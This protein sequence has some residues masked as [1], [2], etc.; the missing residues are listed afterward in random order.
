[1]WQPKLSKNAIRNKK[2]PGLIA[3]DVLVLGGSRFCENAAVVFHVFHEIFVAAPLGQFPNSDDIVQR[4]DEAVEI[5]FSE[6]KDRG[7]F[8][9]VAT[10]DV[11]V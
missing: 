1:M 4:D 6:L 3:R 9:R 7:R 2:S 10:T 5:G 8:C 11:A